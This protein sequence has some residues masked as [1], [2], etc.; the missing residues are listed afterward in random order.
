MVQHS[1]GC[2]TK[3]KQNNIIVNK[4][5]NNIKELFCWLKQWTRR[6]KTSRGVPTFFERLQ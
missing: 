6:I 2:K 4:T 5:E 1:L 3:D